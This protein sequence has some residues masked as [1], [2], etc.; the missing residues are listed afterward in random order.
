MAM[1]RQDY[2]Y[3]HNSL[4]KTQLQQDNGELKIGSVV[5]NL[6]VDINNK[7][8]YNPAYTEYYG[9]DTI[10]NRWY[11]G[12]WAIINTT[13]TINSIIIP[14]IPERPTASN[15][16][17]IIFDEIK[18]P[19]GEIHK[20]TAVNG[21]VEIQ[22]NSRLFPP[23]LRDDYLVGIPDSNNT[24]SLSQEVIGRYFKVYGKSPSSTTWSDK[25]DIIEMQYN[26]STGYVY[27]KCEL[28]NGQNFSGEIA[29]KIHLWDSREMA[30]AYCFV[31]KNNFDDVQII[32]PESYFEYVINRNIE[33]TDPNLYQFTIK[34][35]YK[36]INQLNNNN[37]KVRY[38]TGGT[39]SSIQ[40]TINNGFLYHEVVLKPNTFYVIQVLDQSFSATSDNKISYISNKNGDDITFND[41]AFFK[42]SNDENNIYTIGISGAV[43]GYK[44][45]YIKNGEVYQFKNFDSPFKTKVFLF[46]SD[47][48]WQVSR[49]GTIISRTNTNYEGVGIEGEDGLDATLS[50][51]EIKDIFS[52]APQLTLQEDENN[53]THLFVNLPGGKEG[54]NWKYSKLWEN[55]KNKNKPEIMD[56]LVLLVCRN[57]LTTEARDYNNKEDSRQYSIIRTLQRNILSTKDTYTSKKDGEK[58]YKT[59]FDDIQIL[60]NEV[61]GNSYC[62]IKNGILFTWDIYSAPTMSSNKDKPTLPNLYNMSLFGYNFTYC[63]QTGSINK[64]KYTSFSFAWGY[65]DPETKEISVLSDYSIPLIIDR[66]A[67]RV[68]SMNEGKTEYKL[69]QNE[70]DYYE[71]YSLKTLQDADDAAKEYYNGPAIFLI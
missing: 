59:H 7:T 8:L 33:Q 65:K 15:T 69:V 4:G 23:R 67:V 32:L 71:I 70:K 2:N 68:L 52:E 3:I 41:Y 56:N 18:E 53:K 48:A 26:N 5:K 27:I 58:Y 37:I 64:Y 20:V 24:V 21:I 10:Q 57:F 28:R 35:Y 17:Y 29:I 19:N 63:K 49:D 12:G 44:G 61:Y 60:K 31:E 39:S 34:G 36:E 43:F 25:I 38:I 47:Y 11:C 45:Y 42:T 22:S 13:A 16:P 55:T 46:E 50:E 54:S 9:V 66:N 40:D 14:E 62:K 30:T 6:V 51:D 1:N